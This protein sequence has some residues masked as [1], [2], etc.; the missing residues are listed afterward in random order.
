V[1]RPQWPRVRARERRE[2]A[3]PAPAILN[4]LAAAA[5]AG[6]VEAMRGK[7]QA[8]H[9]APARGLWEPL[10]RDDALAWH[11]DAGDGVDVWC[12]LDRENAR[13]LLEIA[14]C[15]P[16]A[17]R[18]TAV[19]RGIVRETIER[20]LASTGR[21]WDER[22]GA[23]FPAASGW[24][25]TLSIAPSRGA[26]A[27]LC[28]Y[29]PAAPEPLPPAVQRVDLRDVPVTLTAWLPPHGVRVG[30]VAAWR[31]GWLVPLGFGVEAPARVFAGAA[32]VA[33]GCLGA[34]RGTRAIRIDAGVPEPLH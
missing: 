6:A 10:D 27:E 32:L 3:D 14:L 4:G 34:I 28:F 26:A 15:G 2:H 21:V 18:P 5:E 23:R 33:S 7:A 30:D 29:A 31:P 25:C 13:A 9:R 1:N 24:I 11:S 20:V 19:E 12:A 16:A 22:T 17:P 8:T